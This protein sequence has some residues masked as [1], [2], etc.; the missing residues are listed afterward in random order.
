[1][2]LIEGDSRSAFGTLLRHF[3]L[4]A[5]L[6]QESLAER[7]RVSIATIGTLERGKRQAPHRETLLLLAEALGLSADDRS[8]LIAAAARKSRPRMQVAVAV[9]GRDP[10]VALYAVQGPEQTLPLQLSSLV[11]REVVVAEVG[12]LVSSHR[13]VT[14]V[15]V[16]GVGKTRVALHVAENLSSN[17]PGGVRL[18]EL[19]SVGDAAL[20]VGAIARAVGVYDSPKQPLLQMVVESL[21]RRRLLL[22]LD[23]CEHVIDEVCRVAYTILGECRGVHIL[24]TSQEPLKISGERI[25]RVPLLAYPSE[26][27]TS[28]EDAGAYSAI[29]L[30]VD[31]AVDSGAAFRLSDENATYVGEI[32]RRLD[33]IPLAIELAAAR[34]NL[35]QPSQLARMLDDRFQIL[36][37]GDRTAPSR[38]QTMEATLAWSYDLLLPPEQLLFERLSAFAAPCTLDMIDAVCADEEI[39]AS[40]LL[41]L[42]SSLVNKS[43]VATEEIGGETRYRLLES[44]RQYA[45]E[46]LGKRGETEAIAGRHAAAYLELAHHF[47]RLR[48]TVNSGGNL[49]RVDAFLNTIEREHS[50]FTAAAAWCLTG[51]GD[52]GIGQRLAAAKIWGMQ[53]VEPLRWVNA[54]LDAVDSSTTP[55]MI[56]R[57]EARL[58]DH[59]EQRHEFDRALAALL[60]ETAI[61]RELG[62]APGLAASYINTAMILL[63][64]GRVDQ[65]EKIILAANAT[66]GAPEN[67][68]LTALLKDTLGTVRLARGE[69]TEGRSL[70]AEALRMLEIEGDGLRAAVC[71][72]NLAAQEFG[73]GNAGAALEH[74]ANVVQVLRAWRHADLAEC[75]SNEAT[76]LTALD[77]Y[78]E[79]RER[80]FESLN[81]ALQTVADAPA[82]AIHAVQRLA[83]V[84]ALRPGESGN[85]E[86]EDRTSAAQL[87]GYADARLTAQ[88]TFRWPTDQ[89]DVDRALAALTDALGEEEVAA[90]EMLGAGL[91]DDRAIELALTLAAH[92]VAL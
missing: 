91:S 81:V 92:S 88:G 78:E 54:A 63:R 65:A 56:A 1:V 8:E 76:F 47:E 87:L 45:R 75:L 48:L 73:L 24:A 10:V 2:E 59:L 39:E 46:R 34:V 89:R 12:A 74:S 26:A 7:A 82:R 79:A 25:Y 40:Q 50:N 13:L 21:K 44:S 22:V 41:E 49:D 17:W 3:R 43:L 60:R 30:F 62:D 36:T 83:A 90:L 38:Q 66:E 72:M 69:Y 51:G 5:E 55:Q 9:P 80:A 85:G 57:L 23:N 84:A 42:L 37:G 15:G 20:V 70:N 64:L 67:W 33:G 32:C 86:H 19:A 68:R 6:S 31:R 29:A 16:G 53:I 28:A 71:E 11:G 14:L 4:R 61:L 77:R 58:A 27:V 18:V 35:L 52:V